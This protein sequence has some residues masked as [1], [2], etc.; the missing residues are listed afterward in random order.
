M[1]SSKELFAYRIDRRPV[2]LKTLMS[3]ITFH[4]IQFLFRHFKLN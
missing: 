1:F 4:W 2:F 3:K